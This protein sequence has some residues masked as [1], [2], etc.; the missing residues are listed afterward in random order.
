MAADAGR[1]VLL[2]TVD[3]LRYDA[4]VRHC[5][6]APDGAEATLA[7]NGV[8]FRRAYATGPGT[9]PSF[10]ALLTGTHALSHGGLGPLSESRPRLA[11]RLGRAGLATGGFQCNPF[12]SR[13]FEYDAGFDRF[14]DYQHPLM[15]VATRLFPRGIEI[16]NPRLRRVDDVLHL[17]DLV[18]RVYSAVSGK[19]RPYV[20]ADVVTDDAVEWMADADEP[21]FCWAHYMD[22]HHPC[23]PPAPYREQFGVADVTHDEVAEWYA[24]LV[25][26]PGALDA[27]ALER[28]RG[29][30]RAAVSYTDD[31]VGRLVDHLESSGRYDDTLVVLTSDHGELFGEH[32]RYGKPER[33]DDELLH[34]PL[35]VANGPSHL[36]AAADDLVSL[37]DV[38][39]L[40][41]DALGLSVPDAYE[42]RRPGVDEPRGVVLA[43]HEVE[44]DVV[45]GA[46]SAEWRYE[47]DEHRGE[48]RLYDVGGDSV[49][50][51]RP[52]DERVR[53]G[54]EEGP[55]AVRTAV[56]DRLDAVYVAPGDVEEAVDEAARD[57]LEDLGYL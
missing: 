26:D 38:P 34:V 51:V 23:H 56:R 2:V 24:A 7:S 5:D 18:K 40:V 43:E 16:N 22:V 8:S 37:V 52:G 55:E 4:F 31:Q 50:E 36:E 1:N 19:P 54:D 39:P 49:V 13:F 32:G 29:L 12:L 41:H 46:R 17:T 11:R 27:D 53:A 30:Y 35:V 9:S 42:G 48:T 3:S 57:R 45:V 20:P 10:P 33:M 47:V 6:R 25:S 15:G 28:L 44:G 14:E 21:F